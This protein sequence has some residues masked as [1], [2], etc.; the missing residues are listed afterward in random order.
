MTPQKARKMKQR[1]V[2]KAQGWGEKW[3][4][5]NN[6]LCKTHEGVME[7]IVYIIHKNVMVMHYLSLLRKGK[8]VLSGMDTR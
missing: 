4:K 1:R 7:N 3:E 6:N 8:T 5:K 2:R